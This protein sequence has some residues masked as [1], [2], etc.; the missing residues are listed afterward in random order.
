MTAALRVQLDRGVQHVEAKRAG[1]PMPQ[2][3][4]ELW[5]RAEIAANTRAAALAEHGAALDQLRSEL[6]EEFR[7]KLQ[8]YQAENADARSAVASAARQLAELRQQ[9]VDD[10]EEQLV[11]LSL[12]IARKVCVQ[13]VAAG[14]CDIDPIVEQ[15]LSRLSHDEPIQIQM[16]PDDMARS[17]LAASA[18]AG[19]ALRVV[20]NPRVPRG[21]V[22]VE[23]PEGTIAAGIESHLA[24]VAA[25]LRDES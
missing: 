21:E 11:E 15:A 1:E 6:E 3:T 24:Q 12:E 22:I 18:G 7:Q 19:D 13:E 25:A 20:G 9:M 4:A 16:N 8:Q 10:M 14:R 23:T 5:A 2:A 17:E